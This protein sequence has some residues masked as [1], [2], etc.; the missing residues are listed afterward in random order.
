MNKVF[1]SQMPSFSVANPVFSVPNPRDEG[2][3]S[4]LHSMTT[5][6]KTHY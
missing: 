2:S 5:L 3:Q 4:I 1:S 6:G